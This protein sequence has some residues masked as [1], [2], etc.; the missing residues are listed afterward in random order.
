LE[1]RNLHSEERHDT[2]FYPGD[3]IKNNEIDGHV[4]RM[5]GRRDAYEVLLGKSAEERPLERT[6]RRWT[7]N[8]TTDLK[9]IG[10][11]CM[12]LIDLARTGTGGRL[13]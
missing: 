8:V 10:W 3:Q 13:V 4:A 6:R 7:T 12:D 2:K 11:E 1:W 9:V 5:G